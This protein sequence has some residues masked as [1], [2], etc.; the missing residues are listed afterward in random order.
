MKIPLDPTPYP[1]DPRSR[2]ISRKTKDG[3]YVYVRDPAGIVYVLPD[4]PHTHPKVLGGGCPA[5]YAG[6]LTISGR[7]VRDVTNLSGT[8][9]CDDRDGLLAVAEAIRRQGVAVM[10]GAVRFFPADGSRPVVLQ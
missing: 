8:F 1:R 2:A 10:P 4:G 9:Q 6:D 7:V 3:N 5:M